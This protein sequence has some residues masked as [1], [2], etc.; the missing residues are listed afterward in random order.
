M[1]TAKNVFEFAILG[2][3]LTAASCTADEAIKAGTDC[4]QT[5]PVGAQISLAKEASGTCGAN[6]SYTAAGEVTASGTCKGSGECQVVCTYPKC[7]E[8]QTLVI[9]ATEFRCE[10]ASALCAKVDCDGHGECRVVN[11]AAQCSCDDGYVANGAHCDPETQPVVQTISP[12][13][14]I[15]GKETTF[16]VSGQNLPNALYAKVDNCPG[17]SFV[18]RTATVQEFV[19]TPSAA[20]VALRQLY[21][22]EGGAKLFQ[23]EATFSCSD[24]QIDG[25]CYQQGALGDEQGCTVC[26]T[27]RS[28]TD[29]SDN[30][31]HPCEDGVFCNGGDSCLGGTCSDHPGDPCQPNGTFCDGVEV[32]DDEQQKCVSVNPPCQDNAVYCDGTESC[33]ETADQCVSSGDPCVDDG[34]FCNGVETCS[35]IKGRCLDMEENPTAPCQ[36]DEIECN[37]WE[38]CDEEEDACFTDPPCNGYLLCDSALEGTDVCT[39]EMTVSEAIPLLDPAENPK[40]AVWPDGRFVVVYQRSSYLYFRTFSSYASPEGDT[41]ILPSPGFDKSVV[42][43]VALPGKGFLVAAYGSHGD[44]SL[45]TKEGLAVAEYSAD[46]ELLKGPVVISG[47]LSTGGPTVGVLEFFPSGNVGV[48][49]RT[50]T[51]NYLLRHQLLDSSLA[52]VFGGVWEVNTEKMTGSITAPAAAVAPN[53]SHIVVW[54]DD[55]LGVVAERNASQGMA[56]I[57]HT[58]LAPVIAEMNPP[59]V[60]VD[61][62]FNAYIAYPTGGTGAAATRV[63]L[64]RWGGQS[65]DT[66]GTSVELTKWPE[67]GYQDVDIAVQ[68]TG[69]GLVV[70]AHP[71]MDNVNNPGIGYQCFKA[72]GH[73]VEGEGG[74]GH[75]NDYDEVGQQTN[76][77]VVTYLSGGYLAVW[78]S[79][80]ANKGKISIGV[81]P[82]CPQE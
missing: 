51:M 78:Q 8:N 13:S 19:C 62:D 46:G 31:G 63:H 80:S 48:V 67:P 74:W 30:D 50:W 66:P 82:A 70:F 40:I 37:G 44:V 39:K 79:Y 7:G 14:A 45:G 11:D 72:D 59:A 52:E 9:S 81:L 43:V 73:V 15:V 77:D 47:S 28:K 54:A 33:D 34:L 29:W 56:D 10:A 61:S 21:A 60:A 58:L 69:Y 26:D 36:E 41:A 42:D 32:C 16:T 68:P 3:C 18:S 4:D 55:A 12:N 76:P 17:L 75:V 6:G 49:F 25:K 20:G 53:G 64:I 23:D 57:D 27:K 5:C 71:L 24:C 35:E 38:Y 65:Y 2:L 1:K 22:L